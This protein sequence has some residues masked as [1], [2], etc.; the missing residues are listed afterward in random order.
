MGGDSHDAEPAGRG[1]PRDCRREPGHR[2]VW[3]RVL[4][5]WLPGVVIAWF[6]QE[7]GWCCW[8]EHDHPHGHPWP[9]FAMYWYD[10]RAIVR[11]DPWDQS[12]PA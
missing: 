4:G 10:P 12:P 11:R 7:T 9:V 3:I 2:H 1:L 5:R 6:G 8:V